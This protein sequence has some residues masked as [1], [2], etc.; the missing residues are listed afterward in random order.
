[1]L[2]LVILAA[3]LLFCL[4]IIPVGLPGTWLMLVAALLYG[5]LT[6]VE[7]VGTVT[8]VSVF[9]LALVAELIEFSLSLK[10]TSRYGGSRR[11]GW[12]AILGGI[13]GAVV[14]LPLPLVGSIMGAF[15]GAFLGALVAE[16]STGSGRG[17]ATEAAKGAL[18]GRVVAT[19][20]KCSIGVVMAAWIMG[21][22]L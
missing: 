20:V 17:K 5:P 8:L 13:V 21:A 22:A 11:A 16:L 7:S 6:G 12:G 4:L 19:A 2:G 10:Y 18:M 3:V 15:A 9:L 1:M 14:G